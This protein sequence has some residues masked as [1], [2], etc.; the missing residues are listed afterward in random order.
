MTP[1]QKRIAKL[2]RAMRRADRAFSSWWND[3]DDGSSKLD[4]LVEAML[5][6]RKAL[7]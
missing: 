7:R 1:E 3:P 6:M 5:N 2:E 4:A